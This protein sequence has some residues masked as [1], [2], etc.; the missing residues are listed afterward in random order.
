MKFFKILLLVLC[1]TLPLNCLAEGWQNI[2][3]NKPIVQQIDNKNMKSYVYNIQ[4]QIKH[5][6]ESF[7]FDNTA[8]GETIIVAEF[9]VAKDG[10]LLDSKI[11]K[12]SNNLM[13]DEMALDAI[14]KNAPFKPIPSDLAGKSITL[15]MTFVISKH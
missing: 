13:I 10:S 4:K 3:S 1:L 12:S 5:N 15:Q 9:T 7:K 14:R 2:S 8:K 11:L 6:W